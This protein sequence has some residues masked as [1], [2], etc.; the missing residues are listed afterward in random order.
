[1][2][3][4][5]YEQ[6]RHLSKRSSHREILFE[7]GVHFHY[8]FLYEKDADLTWW[9]DFGFLHNHCFINVEWIHPRMHY[10]TLLDR[11]AYKQVEHLW[12]DHD[13]LTSDDQTTDQRLGQS[14]EK[15][16]CCAIDTLD[17][18]WYEGLIKAK[19]QLNLQTNFIIKASVAVEWYPYGKFL[20]ICAPV[21][22]RSQQDVVSLIQIIKRIL[23][24][25]LTLEQAFPNYEY[26]RSDWL[27]DTAIM[28]N[29]EPLDIQAHSVN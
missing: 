20:S 18:A 4:P 7:N 2:K 28:E 1:M 23:K 8:S 14:S 27:R 16:L 22:I 21:E 10:K 24:Q 11:E 6:T 15:A 29:V 25:E 19:Q 12:H 26:T 9:N 3:N 5:Y 13:F 17:S